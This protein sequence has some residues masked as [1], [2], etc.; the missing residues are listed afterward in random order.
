[1]VQDFSWAQVDNYVVNL[2]DSVRGESWSDIP[3]ELHQFMDW[4][5]HNDSAPP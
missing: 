1:M 4:E 5:F 2:L 3:K